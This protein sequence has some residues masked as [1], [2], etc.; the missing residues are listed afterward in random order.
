MRSAD[1]EKYSYIDERASPALLATAA[2]VIFAAPD[3]SAIAR[4]ASMS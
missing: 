2:T 3:S 4:A 1:D